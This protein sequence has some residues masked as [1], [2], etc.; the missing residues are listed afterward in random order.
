MIACG[1]GCGGKP[2]KLVPAEGLVTIGGVPAANISVQFLPDTNVKFQTP[3]SQGLTN[4]KGRFALA[5][6]DG[7][8]GAV[9]GGHAV[10]LVDAQDE[11]VEQGQRPTRPPRISDRFATL[12]AGLRAEVPAEGGSEILIE[13]PAYRP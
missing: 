1:V 9:P 12:A 4:A 8:P 3:S 2:L 13:V 5:S 6:Q 11:R 10:L 7:K